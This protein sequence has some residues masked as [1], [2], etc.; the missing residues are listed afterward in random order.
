MSNE[1]RDV[2][3]AREERRKSTKCSEKCKFEK[4]G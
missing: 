3:V 1:G 2:E 4:Y